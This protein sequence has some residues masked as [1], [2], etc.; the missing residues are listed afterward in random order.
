MAC[1]A[2]SLRQ[3]WSSG[4]PSYWEGYVKDYGFNDGRGAEH[5]GSSRADTRDLRHTKRNDE[6]LH[7]RPHTF[8]KD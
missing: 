6:G 4:L 1:A 5:G 2:A 7:A 3:E 8:L